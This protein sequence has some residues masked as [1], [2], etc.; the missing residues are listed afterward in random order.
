MAGDDPPREAFVLVVLARRALYR[1]ERWYLALR[2]RGLRETASGVVPTRRGER[3]YLALVTAV[4]PAFELARDNLEQVLQGCRDA[5]IEPYVMASADPLRTRV[6]VPEAD[7]AAL[8]AALRTRWRGRLAYVGTTWR[9]PVLLDDARMATLLAAPRWTFCRPRATAAGAPL[10]AVEE[11]CEIV[12]S[13]VEDGVLEVG[14]DNRAASRVPVTMLEPARI[15][16]LERPY[17]STRPLV[18][19]HQADTISFPIDA[20]YT[21]VDGDDPR[22]RSARD[23]HLAGTGRLNQEA[24]NPS[25]YQ[26]R[27]ELRYSLRSLWLHAEWINHVWLVTDRQQPSWLVASDPRLTVVDHRE[28]FDDH[29]VLPTFNSHAIEAQLHR[30]PGIAEHLLYFND[31]VFLGRWVPPERFF[32]SNGVP[33]YFPSRNTLELGPASVTDPP[34]MSAAKNGRDLLRRHLGRTVTQKLKHTPHPVRRSLL[35]ELELRFAE[36][37]ARTTASRF[38]QPSDLSFVSSLAHHY[39]FLTGRAVPSDLSYDYLDLA[40][41]RMPATL[42]TLQ[43]ERHLEV[44]CLN[45]TDGPPA[46]LQRRGSLARRFLA[47]YF[48][49]AGP[50]ER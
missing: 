38:R 1:I 19:T 26:D 13:R 11:A 4:G 31:D 24:A 28:I 9:R 8:L 49:A 45:D 39:A 16:I 43:R 3:W 22:W 50:F 18:V 30:I 41:D 48:P 27:D 44:F 10:A 5:G 47:Q 6:S 21:W 29:S 7:R 15:E 46:L 34:V 35:E 40:E 42:Q 36:E 14:L 2:R 12:F 33:R 32:L 20:V 17:P 23:R 25:R 37:H